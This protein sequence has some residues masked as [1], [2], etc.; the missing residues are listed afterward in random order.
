MDEKILKL[1]HKMK[2]KLDEYRYEHTLGVMYTAAALAMSHEVDME[3]ALLAGLLHDCAKCYSDE[4]K[5]ALCKKYHVHL[6]DIEKKDT[7]LMHARLGAVLA[8]EKYGIDDDEVCHA[9]SSHTTGAPAMSRLQQIIFIADYIEPH[10]DR[11]GNLDIIRRAAFKNLDEACR[12]ILQDTIK[13]LKNSP[14]L[15]DPMTKETYDYYMCE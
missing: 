4:K 14:K 11:A 15:V 12:L 1:Q 6:A 5:L 7:A 3:R 2:K 10:R 8:K 13:Y 9:I